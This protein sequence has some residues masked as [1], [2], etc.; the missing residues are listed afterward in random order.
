M[1]TQAELFQKIQDLKYEIDNISSYVQ[2]DFDLL[3]QEG[4]TVKSF[5]QLSNGMNTQLYK[6]SVKIEQ[7]K[8]EVDEFFANKIASKA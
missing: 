6:L 3:E 2:N 1:A 7:I 5:L 4:C 8:D